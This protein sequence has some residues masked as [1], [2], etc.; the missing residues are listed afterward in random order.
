MP[1]FIPFLV[2]VALAWTA[3]GVLLAKWLK[4]AGHARPFSG[5]ELSGR[6]LFGG[7]VGFGRDVHGRGERS[8]KG[9]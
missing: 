8:G 7:G 5:R 3:V 4:Q 6:E 2:I 1:W 9:M